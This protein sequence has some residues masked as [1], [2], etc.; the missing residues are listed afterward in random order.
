M[1]SQTES[2]IR[3]SRN[4]VTGL[5]DK[6]QKKA[7]YKPTETERLTYQYG[8]MSPM[9]RIQQALNRSTAQSEPEALGFSH[10]L[11]FGLVHKDFTHIDDVLSFQT[12]RRISSQNTPPTCIR[13]EIRISIFVLLTARSDTFS[14][15]DIPCHFD[16]Y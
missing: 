14:V 10:R 11:L 9:M 13:K 7:R 2:R 16:D 4:P 8:R 1:K 6:L 12:V 3:V 5:C 15:K